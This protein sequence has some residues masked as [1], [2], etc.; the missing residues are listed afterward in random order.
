MIIYEL[1]G[2]E[3]PHAPPGETDPLIRLLTLTALTP[4]ASF[5]SNSGVTVRVT[6]SLAGGFAVS[7]DNP[8]APSV[9]VP[10][11]FQLSYKLAV[12]QLRDVGLVPKPT[13]GSQSAWVYRQSPVAGTMVARGSTVSLTLHTGPIQ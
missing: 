12:K 2:V 6:A 3:D 11:L 9:V 1:A 5:T 7:I 8:S 4:G 10:N 13:S